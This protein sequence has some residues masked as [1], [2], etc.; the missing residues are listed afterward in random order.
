MGSPPADP[1]LPQKQA[2]AA[3]L[4]EGMLR[5]AETLAFYGLLLTLPRFGGHPPTEN[6][7]SSS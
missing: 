4:R 2:E 1:T 6:Q 3:P 5:S 7:P